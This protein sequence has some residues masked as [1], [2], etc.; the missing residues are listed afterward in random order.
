MMRVLTLPSVTLIYILLRWNSRAFSVKF[1]TSDLQPTGH[2]HKSRP[3][4]FPAPLSLLR[5]GH[6][7][8]TEIFP[9]WTVTH[10][11]RC[12]LLKLIRP[13]TTMLLRDKF[14]VFRDTVRF[15][16]RQ[17][18]KYNNSAQHWAASVRH[19]VM[20]ILCSRIRP[21]LIS[22]FGDLNCDH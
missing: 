1:S 14:T 16:W 3:Q 21:A 18:T 12:H 17:K 9:R 19:L 15:Q 4:H 10:P 8:P 20:N 7:S 2:L 11:Y 22:E 13:F 6:E 5:L